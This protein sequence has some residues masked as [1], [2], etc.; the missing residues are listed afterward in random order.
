MKVFLKANVASLVASLVDYLITI[1][2]KELLQTDAVLASIT[3][4]ICGGITNF[5]IGRNWVFNAKTSSLSHQGWRYFVAWAGN[6]V[7]NSLG[8]YLLI[9]F[10]GLHY[11]AA[12]IITSITVAVGY[13]YPIQKRYVFKNN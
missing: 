7:L 10:A 2:V 5:F 9:H 8:V 13:N 1:L 12:K 3:G 4:T 6:L 11:V